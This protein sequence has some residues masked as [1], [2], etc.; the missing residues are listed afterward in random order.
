MKKGSMML[1]VFLYASLVSLVLLGSYVAL[2]GFFAIPENKPEPP[3]LEVPSAVSLPEPVSPQWSVLAVRDGENEITAFLFR[4]ADFLTDT[5]VFIEVPKDTKVELTSGGYE[6]LRVHQ[7]EIPEIYMV[8]DLCHIF[9]EELWCMAAEETG[10]SLL[11]VRPRECYI[12]EESIYKEYTELVDGKRRFL[13]EL[14]VKEV[15]TSAVLHGVTDDSL[16]EEMVYLE[17]YKDIDGVLYAT[18]PGE[19]YAQEYKPDFTLINELV[20]RLKTGMYGE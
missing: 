8:S 16:K 18:L 7:P 5:L 10:A 14:P 3:V 2:S 6:V 13:Q 15:I 17:S 19:S 20:E 1:K 11:G 9:R 4:Y 12:I